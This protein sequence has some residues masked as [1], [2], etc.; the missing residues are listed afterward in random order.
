MIMESILERAMQM[1]QPINTSTRLHQ[2]RMRKKTLRELRAIRKLEAEEQAYI[3]EIRE[4]KRQQ[5]QASVNE[6]K[7]LGKG[8]IGIIQKGRKK[9]GDFEASRIRAE[10]KIGTRKRKT[11]YP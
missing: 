2:L 6:L 3:K 8:F 11:I 1:N 4:Q 7:G 10:P 9:L 5:R